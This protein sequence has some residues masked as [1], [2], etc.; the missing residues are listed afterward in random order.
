[1][2]DRPAGALS[3]HAKRSGPVRSGPAPVRCEVT[4]PAEDPQVGGPV[5]VSVAV[6]VMQF[7][8]TG[9]AAVGAPP[10]AGVQDGAA[11]PL[12]LPGGVLWAPSA[13]LDWARHRSRHPYP[14]G[15]AARAQRAEPDSDH[16]SL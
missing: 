10:A 16:R 14:A 15:R 7:Q 5:V 1:M 4:R 13:R 9:P 2:Q 12:I 3:R 6:D 8:P 11:Q